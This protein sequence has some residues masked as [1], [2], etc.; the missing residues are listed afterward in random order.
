MVYNG[1]DP[2]PVC[3]GEMSRVTITIAGER[4]CTYC[5]RPWISHPLSDKEVKIARDI[6]GNFLAQLQDQQRS[7]NR[8]SRSN[9][10]KRR[11]DRI[12]DEVMRLMAEKTKESK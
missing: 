1:N 6:F 9:R 11:G 5:G 12:Y 4:I 7:L 10:R 3:S 2:C 8:K